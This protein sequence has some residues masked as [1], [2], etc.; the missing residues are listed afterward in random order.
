MKPSVPGSLPAKASDESCDNISVV[1]SVGCSFCIR[2]KDNFWA[3]PHPYSETII[4]GVSIFFIIIP[5]LP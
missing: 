3:E 2:S 1:L 4:I 5:T